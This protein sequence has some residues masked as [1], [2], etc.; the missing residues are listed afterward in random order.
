MISIII[1]IYNQAEHLP[2]LLNSL[3]K[4]TYEN[5]EIIIVNDGSTDDLDPVKYK[6]LFGH[7]L[8][9]LE[10]ANKGANAARNYGAKSALGEYLIFCD[11]DIIMEADM[12]GLMLNKL[13]ENA[14]ASFCYSSFLWGRKKFIL[15]PYDAARLKKTP[16]INIASLIKKSHFPGFDEKLKRFQDWDLWLT[17]AERGQGGVWLE[18]ILYRV[19]LSGSQTMSHWLP[20]FAYR[21]FPFLP[22]VKK[23]NQAKEIIYKKHKL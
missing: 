15:W 22:A 2:N 12:L 21:L 16:Y 13:R 17:L 6:R 23:Y 8:T 9:Y 4:Q 3:K 19:N 11:A 5:Y 20:S 7:K 14:N 18:K 1:P 10:Q